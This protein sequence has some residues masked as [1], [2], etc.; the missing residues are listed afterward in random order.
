MDYYKIL[1]IPPESSIDDIKKAYKKMALKNHPDKTG[2]KTNDSFHQ[3]NEA[4]FILSNPERR[5]NYDSEFLNK[6]S[7][8]NT[9]GIFSTVLNIFKEQYFE[10]LKKQEELKK[11]NIKLKIKLKIYEVL[12]DIPVKV[13]YKRRNKNGIDETVFFMLKVNNYED[14]LLIYPDKGHQDCKSDLEI[15]IEFSEIEM[16]DGYQYTLHDNHVII[17]IPISLYEG[18]TR[19]TKDINYFNKTIKLD[20]ETPINNN[21]II[22]ENYGLKYGKSEVG[23]LVVKFK[24]K[25]DYSTENLDLIKNTFE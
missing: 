1:G 11:N 7:E 8:K 4:Y 17:T 23:V 13:E 20:V 3:I 10:Y 19:F 21:K 14:L 6:D 12:N 25:T 22:L 9:N 18:M 16:F 15:F 5:K 24:F 2:G